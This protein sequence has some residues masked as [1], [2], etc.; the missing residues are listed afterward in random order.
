[1]SDVGR[2]TQEDPDVGLS[3]LWA[4]ERLCSSCLHTHMDTMSRLPSS[5]SRMKGWDCG[6][7]RVFHVTRRYVCM[8]RRSHVLPTHQHRLWSEAG[9][10]ALLHAG[11]GKEEKCRHG[12][13]CEVRHALTKN[14]D[15][16]KRV[17][18]AFEFFLVPFWS[19]RSRTWL[20][21]TNT[22]LEG[23]V[24]HVNCTCFILEIFEDLTTG[25]QSPQTASRN[26]HPEAAGG[27][28]YQT[29]T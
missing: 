6:R 26:L 29:R 25:W 23:N 9:F 20:T 5:L 4:R 1:M 11:N 27:P 16:F 7:V 2:T 10:W 13:R 19:R 8:S 17:S 24:K 18:N 28:G 12:A 21:R 3:M 15:A 14:A 22:P